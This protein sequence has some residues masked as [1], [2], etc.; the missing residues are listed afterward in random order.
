MATVNALSL[1]SSGES[2]L[3]QVRRTEA[4]QWFFKT[5]TRLY[6]HYESA[7]LGIVM[8]SATHPDR[9]M[10]PSTALFT[11]PLPPPLNAYLYPD[12]LIVAAIDA[13]R[14]A[15]KNLDPV[16]FSDLCKELIA[17]ASMQSFGVDLTH[18]LYDVPAMPMLNVED[19]LESYFE[20]EEEEEENYDSTPESEDL[21]DDE[22]WDEEDSVT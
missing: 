4:R 3:V 14:Q 18:A 9:L 7:R 8:L 16:V 6:V 5:R 2:A 20:E 13:E 10:S 22:A 19:D 15:P 1:N 12:N 21:D 11:F 17:C